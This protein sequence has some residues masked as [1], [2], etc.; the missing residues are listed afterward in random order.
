MKLIGKI[1]NTEDAIKKIEENPR[2]QRIVDR[3]YERMDKKYEK[4]EAKGNDNKIK[5]L[6]KKYGYDYE[7]AKKAGLSPDETGHWP[8][9]GNDGLILKGKKHPS[10]IL[11][12]KVEKV[13]GNKII[14]SGGRQYSITKK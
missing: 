8:S 3:R 11:T 13:L 5:K 14:N 9:I 12:K 4:A 2:I 7:S 6:D 1:R 10:M